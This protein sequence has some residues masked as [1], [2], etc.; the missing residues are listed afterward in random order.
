[1]K[2]HRQSNNERQK[3]RHHTTMA[4]IQLLKHSNKQHN[5]T[6]ERFTHSNKWKQYYGS[7][8]WRDLRESQL[9]TQPLCECCLA[10][11]KVT[12]AT[13]VHH[14]CVFGSA[15]TDDERWY[16]FLKPDNLLSVCNE[17]HAKIHNGMFANES[18]V[19]VQ[20]WPFDGVE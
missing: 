17:C 1:M 16:W 15:P 2:Q 20:Y 14:V 6:H 4:R 7:R 18:T 12:P 11:D 8:A 3:Q 10:H 5:R 13:Q 19:W 9:M